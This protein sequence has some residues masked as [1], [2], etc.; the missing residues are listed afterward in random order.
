M[1]DPV[2]KA[3][4]FALPL[5]ELWVNTRTLTVGVGKNENLSLL[6]VRA[7]FSVKAWSGDCELRRR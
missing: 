7:R 6:A 1:K 5:K 2:Q 3:R 4:L